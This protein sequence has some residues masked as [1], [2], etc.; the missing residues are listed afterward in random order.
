[1]YY[2]KWFKTIRKYNSLNFGILSRN[3]P[4]GRRGFINNE[5]YHGSSIFHAASSMTFFQ[6]CGYNG[7]RLTGSGY[8]PK[9]LIRKRSRSDHQEKKTRIGIIKK[10]WIQLQHQEKK[11]IHIRPEVE[12][13]NVVYFLSSLKRSCSYAWF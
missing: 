5:C 9:P 12:T 3:N 1:M 10:N 2:I 6:S 7:K 4:V 13:N 8:E 11:R